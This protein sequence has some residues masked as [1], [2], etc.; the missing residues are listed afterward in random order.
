MIT[1]FKIFE[2]KNYFNY[3]I[4]SHTGTFVIENNDYVVELVKNDLYT[5]IK[6]LEDKTLKVA[7]SNYVL[8]KKETSSLVIKH[9]MFGIIIPKIEYN[10]LLYEIGRV[11]DE[12]ADFNDFS[13]DKY[14]VKFYTEK[15]IKQKEFNL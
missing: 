5:I 8:I 11:I 12:I 6:L 15:D 3:Y 1:K 7:D 10:N 2:N 9:G 14:V 13:D 4:N